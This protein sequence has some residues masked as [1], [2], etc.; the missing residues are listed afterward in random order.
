MP[1]A[2]KP[3]PKSQKQISNDQVE[4]YVFPETGESLGNPNIPSDFNQFT[5]TNQS[6]IGFNRSEQMS[7]KGD[8]VK[9]F[10]VGLQ[11]INNGFETNLDIPTPVQRQPKGYKFRSCS[12]KRTKTGVW[13]C[14][15]SAR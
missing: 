4:P 10:T 3:N 8:T 1:A 11:D 13:F 2:R 6:G 14:F 12:T 5:P 7:F 15:N 9:P